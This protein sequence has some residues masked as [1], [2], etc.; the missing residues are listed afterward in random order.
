[1]NGEDSGLSSDDDAESNQEDRELEELLLEAGGAS[2]KRSTLRYVTAERTRVAS[3]SLERGIM[4][5]TWFLNFGFL[6]CR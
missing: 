1:M 6:R 3:C 5:I 4:H 2:R